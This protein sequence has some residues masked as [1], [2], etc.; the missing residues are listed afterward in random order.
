[1]NL[2]EMIDKVITI[3]GKNSIE[4]N[5]VMISYADDDIKTFLNICNEFIN[6]P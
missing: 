1:M 4:A 2:K 5:I 6:N 3:Y